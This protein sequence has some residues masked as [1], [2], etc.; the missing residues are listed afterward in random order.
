MKNEKQYLYVAVGFPFTMIEKDR[1]YKE[2]N[3]KANKL[4]LEGNPDYDKELEKIRQEYLS[5]NSNFVREDTKIL[6]A[7]LDY[8][9]I[10]NKKEW[11]SECGYYRYILICRYSLPYY[12]DFS[13]EELK[14]LRLI[15]LTEDDDPFSLSKYEEVEKPD[16]YKNV[17]CFGF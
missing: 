4:K 14:W 5:K 2:Y 17:G 13:E 16:F 7:T 11:D 1:M 6:R 12:N 9:E 10:E 8:S 3:D 15:P